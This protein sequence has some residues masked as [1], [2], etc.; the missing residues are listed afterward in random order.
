MSVFQK[1]ASDLQQASAITLVVLGVF[2]SHIC[3]LPLVP[4]FSATT[5]TVSKFRVMYACA[6][7]IS[8]YLVL[9][10]LAR[11]VA[12]FVS[13][14]VA[15]FVSRGRAAP[16]SRQEQKSAKAPT[17]KEQVVKEVT[18]DKRT[19]GL[20]QLLKESKQAKTA[21]HSHENV[22]DSALYLNTLK[23]HGDSVVSVE[24]SADDASVITA[25]EDKVWST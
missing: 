3:T 22:P 20:K 13:R 16:A 12:G 17:K 23:G 14:A 4:C 18:S 21:A 10:P 19:K 24:I 25:S 15:G 1:L 9:V 7:Y 8:Y 6:V 2:A 11:A 5:D